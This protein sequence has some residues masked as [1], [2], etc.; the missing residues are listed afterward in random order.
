M[1]PDRWTQ[2]P[3]ADRSLA[4]KRVGP[5]RILSPLGAGGMGEV[6]RAH[7]EKLGRDVALK[8]GRSVDAA[9][10][11]PRH[12]VVHVA[13]ATAR[14]AGR[15]GERRLGRRVIL[16]EMTSGARPF[17]GTTEFEVSSAILND[18]PAPLPARVPA[19]LQTV[20]A[21]CLQKEPARRYQR[22][23]EVRAALE[24]VRAGSQS[25]AQSECRQRPR[26]NVA[27]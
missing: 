12:V 15:R 1:D 25:S 18:E 6:F 11:D 14:E 21:R 16:H 3:D 20:I 10:D 26:S 19:A 4:G 22:A 17:D 7:D 8:V 2:M 9:D 23:G 13:G 24:A 27:R 5:Y